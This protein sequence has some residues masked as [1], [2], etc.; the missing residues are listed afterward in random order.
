M[1]ALVPT[2]AIPLM[3]N[4][5]THVVTWLTRCMPRTPTPDVTKDALGSAIR[6]AK[7]TQYT[8]AVA[9][10]SALNIHSLTGMCKAG[11]A[12]NS[13]TVHMPTESFIAAIKPYCHV[14]GNK[15]YNYPPVFFIKH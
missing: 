13:T 10:W 1:T 3:Y 15:N 11:H 14:E 4:C 7:T 5:E 2:P 6:H 9:G 8:S 12:G